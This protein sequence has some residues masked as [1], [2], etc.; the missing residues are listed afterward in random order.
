MELFSEAFTLP[1]EVWLRYLRIEV[2]YLKMQ[3]NPDG[4]MAMRVQRLIQIF[5]RALE[6]NFSM[7]IALELQCMLEFSKSEDQVQDVFNLMCAY[8]YEFNRGHLIWKAWE[9]RLKSHPDMIEKFEK[10]LS[11]F[12][13]QLPIPLR[14][15]EDTYREFFAYIAPYQHMLLNFDKIKI[16]QIHNAT[17]QT[18]REIQVFEDEL[19]RTE[20]DHLFDIYNQYIDFCKEYTWGDDITKAKVILILHERM[21]ASCSN[22]EMSW[23]LYF[24]YFFNQ[25]DNFSLMRGDNASP[26]FNKTFLDIILRAMRHNCPEKTIALILMYA[27]KLSDSP[28]HQ[29]WEAIK[30]TMDLAWEIDFHDATHVNAVC[31]MGFTCLYRIAMTTEDENHVFNLRETFFSAC[32]KYVDKYSLNDD[33]ENPLLALWKGYESRDLMMRVSRG[34]DLWDMWETYTSPSG[35]DSEGEQ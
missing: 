12:M 16:D 21:L 15:T 2:S 9:D 14:H 27:M 19:R 20:N 25:R 7:D 28:P 34:R 22:Q 31:G 4:Q 13:M 30:E 33:S 10:L 26:I 6:D 5:N 23:Q 8:G 11:N 17:Q 32:K 35:D 1:S 3:G 18:M 24:A 29:A